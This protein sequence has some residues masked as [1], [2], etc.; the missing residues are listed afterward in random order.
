MRDR[1]YSRVRWLAASA[2]AAVALLAPVDYDPSV[3][4][5]G[6]VQFADACA[7]TGTCK[8]SPPDI[9]F[10]NGVPYSDREWI[11]AQE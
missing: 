8:S 7:Q 6:T 3:G 4:T 5:V 10:V 9:C 2:I 11:A 1:V